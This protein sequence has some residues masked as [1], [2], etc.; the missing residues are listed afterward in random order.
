MASNLLA[1]ASNLL[2]MASNLLAVASN[3]LAV[4]SNLQ[5]MASN[6]LNISNSLTNPD[7]VHATCFCANW[8]EM[9][10]SHEL[11]SRSLLCTFFDRSWSIYTHTVGNHDSSA[12][13]E[14][15]RAWAKGASKQLHQLKAYHDSLNELVRP[16]SF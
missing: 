13:E 10:V 1:V 15:K 14:L 4:A 12:A 11:A 16:Q 3:L 8:L 2:A 6:L 9:M 7:V 5:A